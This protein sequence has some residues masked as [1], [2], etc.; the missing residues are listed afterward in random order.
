MAFITT[1]RKFYDQFTGLSG[2]GVDTLNSCQ[3]DLLTCII[4]GYFFWSLENVMLT[5]VSST[6]TI[7][8]TSLADQR[9]WIQQGFQVGDIF[10]STATASNNATFTIVTITDKVITVAESVTDESATN[11]S[12]FGITPIT[13]IDYFYNLI[14]NNEN[15]NFISKTDVGV[16]QKYTATGLDASIVTPV[17]A[18]VGTDSYAWVNDVLTGNLTQLKIEGVSFAGDYKQKF[19][20][21]QTFR[22]TRIWTKD[23]Q[24]NFL[25]RIA[26]AEFQNDNHLRHIFQVAGKFDYN[27]PVANHIGGII[28]DKGF[29]AWYNQT[30]AQTRKEYS[31]TSIAY[32]DSVTSD[33][34]QVIEPTLQTDITININSRSGKFVTGT[35]KYLLSL[36]QCPTNNLELQNT[37][38]TLL[39]NIYEDEVMITSDAAGVNGINYST[40]YQSITNAIVA[41]VN[42]NNVSLTFSVIYST[43]IKNYIANKPASD[44]LYSITVACQDIDI[45]TTKGIDRCNLIADFQNQTYDFRNKDLIGLIDYIHCFPYPNYGVAENNT[46]RGFEGDPA[47][48]EVPFWIETALV[49]NVS[50]TLQN[51][52]I[53]IVA[54]KAGENDFIL[55][56]KVFDLSAIRKLNDKQTVDIIG[57]RGFILAE[58]SPFNRSNV[59]RYEDGDSGTKIAYKLQYA[60]VLRYEGWLQAVQSQQGA[61]I[62]VFKNI[63]NVTERWKIYNTN[64][65]ALKLRFLPSAMGYDGFVTYY[66]AETDVVIID[67]PESGPVFEK[68]NQYFNLDGIEVDYILQNEPT[69]IVCNFIGD[70]T[71]FPVGMTEYAGFAF[72]SDSTGSIFDRR[73]A[74]TDLIA[75][76]DTPFSIDNLPALQNYISQKAEN[77]LRITIFTDRIVLDTIYAPSQNNESQNLLSVFKLAY[78]PN[79]FLLKE[80]GSA[81]LQEINNYILRE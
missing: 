79:D 48:I 7:S 74:N 65:W 45:T 15:P 23:L 71:V 26:P 9:S 19:K 20:I 42:A 60:F 5:Y 11:A 58:D 46:V 81:F 47:Y 68:E 63:E 10:R 38:T 69:R 8:F 21:T 22:Q 13:S 66:T 76:S 75:E 57:D 2:G 18:E 17:Y 39:Q 4:H 44:R 30:S 72:I 28:I 50:P 37:S 53:Q 6:K 24:F 29:T 12:C 51:V 27:N 41:F 61:N 36:F 34:L 73:C 1:S 54:T 56:N 77:N 64:G 70:P 80:D 31:I 40:D 32:V 55:E 33:V 59:I 62:D 78:T 25:N 52:E 67:T 43:A 35:S 14:S 49:A 16:P 3:G